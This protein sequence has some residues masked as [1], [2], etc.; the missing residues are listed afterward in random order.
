MPLN[1]NQRPLEA[2][3]PR[4]K[5]RK[6]ATAG[7]FSYERA[8]TSSAGISHLTMQ[9]RVTSLV[10]GSASHASS[11]ERTGDFLHNGPVSRLSTRTPAGSSHMVIT[12]GRPRDLEQT[13]ASI[14][15]P[16]TANQR[17]NT[18]KVAPFVSRSKTQP[19]FS[20]S[21]KSSAGAGTRKRMIPRGPITSPHSKMLRVRAPTLTLQE[22]DLLAFA[23]EWSSTE[24]DSDNEEEGPSRPIVTLVPVRAPPGGLRRAR[25][26]LNQI[27]A[28]TVWRKLPGPVRRDQTPMDLA[29]EDPPPQSDSDDD[30]YVDSD[31]KLP[32]YPTQSS[33]PSSYV[34]RTTK[35]TA[36]STPKQELV[37]A[38]D[39][40]PSNMRELALH[41][42]RQLPFLRRNVR[43]S[44]DI[45]G[46]Q[47]TREQISTTPAVPESHPRVRVEY[48]AGNR[49]FVGYSIHGWRCPICRIMRTMPF[50]T[51]AGLELHL[52]RYHK[53]CVF[54]FANDT[55]DASL[56]LHIK[57]P[58]VPDSDSESEVDEEDD[59]SSSESE[60]EI[61]TSPNSTDQLPAFPRSPTPEQKPFLRGTSVVGGRRPFAPSTS[62]SPRDSPSPPPF[63][64][65]ARASHTKRFAS[66]SSTPIPVRVQRPPRPI[67]PENPARYPT[68]PPYTNLEGPAAVYPYLSD[69]AYSARPG[70]PRLYDLLNELPLAPFGLMAWYVLDREEDIFELDHVCDE[71]KVMRALWGRWIMLNRNAFIADYEKGAKMFIN[72]YWRM[73]HRAAG[74][75]ALRLYLLGFVQNRFLTGPQ[76]CDLLEYYSDL[77]GMDLWK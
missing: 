59:L 13:Q 10:L 16:I 23:S 36:D 41:V 46:V 19:S 72:E 44:L 33:G 30:L 27:A 21:A 6:I 24:A 63:P 8:L 34:A 71:D 5:K 14:I 17:L 18:T 52:T 70:G 50:A 12:P 73:I 49:R 29:N 2:T 69:G 35:H 67:D 7:G 74:F 57:L 3:P 58:E 55:K 64:G 42:S 9:S 47:K 66:P 54:S 53:Y 75:S 60:K 28:K 1:P 40:L 38:L 37:E 11:D 4:P 65:K 76:F 20:V 77:V 15:R 56:V 43:R 68:P 62:K 26:A 48:T 45:L 32:E 25:K 51:R 39:A 22:D 31:L 61:T